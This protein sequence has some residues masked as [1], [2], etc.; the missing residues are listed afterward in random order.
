LKR[1]NR[2][3]DTDLSDIFLHELGANNSDEARVRP[4][5]DRTCTQCLPGA[6]RP[7]Q[8]HSLRRFNAEIYKPLGLTT[9]NTQ[10]TPGQYWNEQASTP[11]V[12]GNTTLRY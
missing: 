12:V 11:A 3:T 4:V 6:R 10:S 8:Q 1:L 7:K 5:S 2:E 9:S